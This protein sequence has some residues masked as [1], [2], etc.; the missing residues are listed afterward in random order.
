[1]LFMLAG[2]E[3]TANTLAFSLYNL[4]RFPE[5]EQRLIDEVDAFGCDRQPCYEDLQQV[6]AALSL[7]GRSDLVLCR[8][9]VPA[10]PP[11]PEA[12]MEIQLT[13]PAAAGVQ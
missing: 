12:L 6:I 4:A 10:W 11:K 5:V 7:L 9:S 13:C 2:Y 8:R 1:M 3:T